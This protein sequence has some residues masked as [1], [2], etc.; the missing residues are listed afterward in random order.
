PGLGVE[1]ELG[2]VEHPSLP[3]PLVVDLN[4]DGRMEVLLA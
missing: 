4:G 1:Q 2:L 3:P